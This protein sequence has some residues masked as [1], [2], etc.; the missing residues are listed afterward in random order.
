VALELKERFLRGE[1]TV[2]TK[3]VEKALGNYRHE[4][5][6]GRERLKERRGEAERRLWGYGVGRKGEGG[7]EKE[8]TMKEIARVYG[9]MV[10]EIE[11]VKR[12]VGRLRGK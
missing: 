3:E 11:D 4:L 12:D 7:E 5:R 2:Y 6:G 1:K 10:G 8:R 9:E